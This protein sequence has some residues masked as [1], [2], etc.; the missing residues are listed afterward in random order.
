MFV[1]IILLV[2]LLVIY[3]DD[4]LNDKIEIYIIF[5]KILNVFIVNVVLN[6]KYLNVFYFIKDFSDVSVVF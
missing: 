1:D 6:Y 3:R 4:I 5:D 2:V